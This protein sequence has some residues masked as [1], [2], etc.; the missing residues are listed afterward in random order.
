[1]CRLN[2]N[3]MT[4]VYLVFYFVNFSSVLKIP[5]FHSFKH[6]MGGGNFCHCGYYKKSAPNN[7]SVDHISSCVER[8]SVRLLW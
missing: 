5:L 7:S 4:V 8:V 3:P 6:N 2:A 1:M